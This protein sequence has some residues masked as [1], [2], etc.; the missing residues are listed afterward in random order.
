MIFNEKHFH[1]STLCHENGPESAAFIYLFLLLDGN[2]ILN[3]SQTL[4]GALLQTDMSVRIWDYE[5][6]SE[7]LPNPQL[8]ELH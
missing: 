3:P 4:R 8:E 2:N 6:Q 1:T 7:I 5:A